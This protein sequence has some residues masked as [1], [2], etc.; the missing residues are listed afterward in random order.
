MFGIGEKPCF[1]GKAIRECILLT[2][3]CLG[4]GHPERAFMKRCYYTTQY[5]N[6]LDDYATIDANWEKEYEGHR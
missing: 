2:T 6:I 3:S 1:S 5:L 4:F